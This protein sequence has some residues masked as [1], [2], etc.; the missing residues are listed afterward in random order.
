MKPVGILLSEAKRAGPVKLAYSLRN[1]HCAREPSIKMGVAPDCRTVALAALQP[2]V[3][4]KTSVGAVA[5]STADMTTE[6]GKNDCAGHL[7][8]VVFPQSVL[9]R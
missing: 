1:E 7:G 8:R 3:N 2:S 6:A 9:G 5:A 4:L